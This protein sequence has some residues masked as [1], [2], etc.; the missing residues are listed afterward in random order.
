MFILTAPPKI[1]GKARVALLKVQRLCRARR[2]MDIKRTLHLKN[3][4]QGQPARGVSEGDS[5]N[6]AR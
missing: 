1:K 2:S 6:N 3:A 4:W 5:P